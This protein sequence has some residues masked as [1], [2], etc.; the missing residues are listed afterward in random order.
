MFAWYRNA[1]ICFVYLDDVLET[2]I[3]KSR[4]FSRGWTL[5]ELIAPKSMIFYDKSWKPIG[6]KED[7]LDELS[8]ITQVSREVLNHDKTLSSICVAQR[9]SWAAK[10]K[11]TRVE[12]KSYCLLGILDINMP[13]LYGEGDKAFYRLQE[14]IVR[15]TYDLSILAWS[16]SGP[17]VG[18]CCAFFAQSPDDFAAC[19]KM[20]L[21]PGAVLDDIPMSMS[22][23]GINITVPEY[24]LECDKTES[25]IKYQYAIKLNCREPGLNEDFFTITIR[26]IGP[27]VFLR[28][29]F[30]DNDSFKPEPVYYS[31]NERKGYILLTKMPEIGGLADIVSFSR[32]TQVKIEVSGWLES[33]IRQMPRKAWDIQ[34]YAFFGTHTSLQNWG[35][36]SFGERF[37]FVCRW[38]REESNW[39]FKGWLLDKNSKGMN[40]IWKDLFLYGD[41]FGFRAGSVMDMLGDVQG[42][43]QGSLMFVDSGGSRKIEFECHRPSD[44]AP[45]WVVTLATGPASKEDMKKSK[46]E[47][48][49]QRKRRR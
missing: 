41:T 22:N 42:E 2:P 13:P 25:S 38:F 17:S 9:L 26:K 19:S 36:V 23:R 4:W 18:D 34:D 6:R 48:L 29:R 40:D 43:E 39:T 24:I 35:A 7:L 46:G 10:R 44:T 30:A 15:S 28:T 27:T 33:E 45:L 14:E 5:Q 47:A 49:P 31:E 3:N 21:V 37:F 8:N 11:T 16:P 32:H 12:D 20:E 1:E